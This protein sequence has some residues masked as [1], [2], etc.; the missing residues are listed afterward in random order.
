MADL[1]SDVSTFLVAGQPPDLDPNF[2]LISGARP[3]A[4]TLA[5]GLMQP[6]G[7]L[8]DINDTARA[9]RDLR[10]Y[11]S[12]RLTKLTLLQ[13]RQA[14]EL[15]A[16]L[17]ERIDSVVVDLSFDQSTN[18]VTVKLTVTSAE[19]PFDLV[20]AVDKVSVSVLSLT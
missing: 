10:K 13:M 15:E 1:G 6:H 12:K 11:L 20:L 4:E 16:R 8:V 3:I 5:R 18:K 7:Q 19:G 17:D 9:G 2:T 14:I